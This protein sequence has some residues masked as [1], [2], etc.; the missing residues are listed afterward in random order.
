MIGDVVER[1]SRNVIDGAII[2]RQRTEYQ[3]Q[4]VFGDMKQA[5]LIMWCGWHCRLDAAH[6]MVTGFGYF[7]VAHHMFS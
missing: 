5:N 1:V 2:Q 4:Q 6:N 3:G 7:P